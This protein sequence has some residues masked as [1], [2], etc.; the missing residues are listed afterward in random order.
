MLR[1]PESRAEFLK[2]A[3]V[4]GAGIF[5]AAPI[6]LASPNPAAWIGKGPNAGKGKKQQ[7]KTGNAGSILK[8]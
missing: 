3:L 2:Q 6:A 7:V 1:E 8:H 4:T 5:A